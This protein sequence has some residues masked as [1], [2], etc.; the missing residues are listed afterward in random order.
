M[1]TAEAKGTRE[2][3][4][5][6]AERLFLA[7]GYEGVSIRDITDAAGANVAA[8]NYH[9]G[10]KENLYREVFRRMVS[11]KAEQTIERLRDAIA[12]KSPPDLEIVFR[13]YIEG[14]LGE[15]LHS[16]DAQNFLRLASDEMSE[17]GIASDILLEEAALPCH[18]SL[19]DAILA[20]RPDVTE[21]KAALII[22]SVFGQMYH[23]VRA[24]HVIKNVSGRDYDGEFIKDIIDHIVDFSLKGIGD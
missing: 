8:V 10:G 5:D 19:K 16:K 20:A 15:F 12:A 13:A 24:R 1:T 17:Q 18:T 22:A 6:E 2:K 14:F 4:L 3:L 7:K 21:E 9:F 11:G 23:F